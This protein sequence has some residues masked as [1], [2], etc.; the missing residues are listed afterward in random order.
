MRNLLRIPTDYESRVYGLDVFRAIAI[1][2]VVL[3]HGG[4][5]IGNVLPGF[6]YIKIIDGV[7]LFFVLSGFL[8]GTI[9][10]KMQEREGK[11]TPGMIF[12]FWKRRWFRTLPNYYLV[13]L[14]NVIFVWLGITYGKL[15]M[16]NWKFLVFAQNFSTHFTDFFWESWSLTIEEW[17]YI[18]TP[19]TLLIFHQSLV[20]KFSI[21]QLTLFTVLIFIFLPLLYRISISGEE[22]DYFWYDVKFRKVVITRLDAIM[23][24]VLFAWLK[25]YYPRSWKKIALPLFI[26]GLVMI[27]VIMYLHESNPTGFFGK[28]LYFSLMGLAAALLLP[29]ADSRKSFKTGFGKMMT[30]ISLISYSMYLVNLSLVADVIR[31]NYEPQSKIEYLVTYIFFWLAVVVISTLLYK[32]FE[33]PMMDIRDKTTS[34]VKIGN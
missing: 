7:E 19:L 27:Y 1:L 30:H 4:F 28:T 18:L 3:G 33:K 25:F 16:F 29:Y 5:L 6:P 15:E 10:I 24:G 26:V 32:Y 23:Y 21:K 17:F 20:K 9:L 31:M 2:T 22:V 34:K 8:I 11:L 13:L 14:L 12:S